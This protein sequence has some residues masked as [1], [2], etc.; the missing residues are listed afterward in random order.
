MSQRQEVSLRE[1]EW[2]EREEEVRGR[3]KQREDEKLTALL[4]LGG[5]GKHSE[6]QQKSPGMEEG[7]CP[8][9]FTLH[10]TDI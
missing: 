3:E 6:V 2:G 9:S 1:K 7:K 8:F 4:A 5:S 10:T